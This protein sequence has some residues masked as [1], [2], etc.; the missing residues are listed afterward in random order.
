MD[1]ELSKIVIPAVVGLLSGALG[2]LVAP[3]IN[4]G[5]EKKKEKIKSR[6][7]LIKDLREVLAKEEIT[8]REFRN[9]ALYSQIKSYLSKGTVEA[10]EGSFHEGPGVVHR[11]TVVMV[12][13]GGRLAGANP[14]KNRTL[15]E[16]TDL[17]KKWG[18]I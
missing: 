14:F 6:A 2:S 18:L 10:I 15:D 1:I 16:L 7:Q 12:V 13:G 9:M 11:E 3:W 17:E 5:I 4:W 8:N